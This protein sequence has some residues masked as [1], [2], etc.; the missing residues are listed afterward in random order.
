MCLSNRVQQSSWSGIDE[1]ENSMR[2]NQGG[3]QADG[4]YYGVSYSAVRCLDFTSSARRSH[5]KILSET[6][7]I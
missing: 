2:E 1:G 3:R 4:R 6:N 5:W 7:M